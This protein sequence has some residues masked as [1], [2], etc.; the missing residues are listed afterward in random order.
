ML[1]TFVTENG[2]ELKL[3]PLNINQ[4]KRFADS[5]QAAAANVL[6]AHEVI[7][8]T[9]ADSMANA[10]EALDVATLGNILTL[11]DLLACTKEVMRI[12]VPAGLVKPKPKF[13]GRF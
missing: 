11:S 6:V 10:G 7:R 2:R 5:K 3:A 12:S 4:M 13:F 9:I 1:A 8:Q